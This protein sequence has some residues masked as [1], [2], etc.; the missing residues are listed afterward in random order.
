[1]RKELSLTSSVLLLLLFGTLMWV[2]F[3]LRSAAVGLPTLT[4]MHQSPDGDLYI[5]LGTDIFEHDS[6]GAPVRRI[7]LRELGVSDVVGDFA[8]FSNGDLLLRVGADERSLTDKIRQYFRRDNL[9][10]THLAVA[11]GGLFRCDITAMTCRPFGNSYKNF[12]QSFFLAVD[13]NSDR[14]LVADSSRHSLLLFSSEGDL[15]TQ[16]EQGLKFPNQIIYRDGLAYVANT[17][18]H[19]IAVF[20]VGEASFKRT[21]RGFLTAE[22]G[23]RLRGH[24]WPSAV[25]IVD[26]QFW[27]V[28]SD[29]DMA[30]GIVVRFNKDGESLG[31]L[32]LPE[33]ADV[34]SVVPFN[35]EVLVNDLHAGRVYRYSSTGERLGDFASNM[36]GERVQQLALEREQYY[37]WMYVVI[38][39]FGVAF[40]IGL[41]LGI[42]QE[43][44]MDQQLPVPDTEDFM[45]THE[46]PGI[47]WIDQDPR[48]VRMVKWLVWFGVT[49]CLLFI[50]LMWILIGVEKPLGFYLTMGFMLAFIIATIGFVSR[51]TR[52]RLGILGEWVVGMDSSGRFAAAKSEHV[53]YSQNRL[54]V[55]NV[56]ITLRT[57]QPCF[58]EEQLVTHLY[59]LLKAARYLTQWQM[60]GV[61]MR[62]RPIQSVFAVLGILL[63]VVIVV[64][65]ENGGAR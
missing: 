62:L 13:W 1:M 29:N 36:L 41:F 19:E 45:F 44:A 49:S 53:L 14:V 37:M 57:N 32:A 60:Q 33:A 3:W 4:H 42:R 34:F 30:N 51:F 58:S 31:E 35:G 27:V 16:T 18:R 25:M 11:K 21:V 20:E 55:G 64:W 23:T 28:N 47:V 7:D 52:Q 22:V 59:P 9:E 56:V 46:T 6:V 39:L 40:I 5:M 63:L 17:N 65:L 10:P 8:F 38:G 12:D 24:I 26:E 48:F 50:P 15:L 61:I 43:M 54:V 2:A